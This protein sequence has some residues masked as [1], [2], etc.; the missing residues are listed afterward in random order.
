M[1]AT[2]S[3]QGKRIVVTRAVEQ[4][5][6]LKTR[7]ESMGATVLLFPAVKFSEPADTTG[8]DRA[9]RSLAGFD[10]VLFTSANAVRFFAARCRKLGVEPDQDAA[11]RCAA[12][13]PATASAVA[14]EGFSVDHVA[15]EFLGVA[16][17]RE[18][19]AS[20]A[21]KKILLPRSERAR[22]DLPNALRSVGAEVTEVVAYHTGGVGAIDP[23]VMRAMREAEVDVISFFSPS[24][25][26]NMRAELG[27]D[28]LS[29]LG[30][31]AA[32]AAVGPVT[33]SA[34]RNAGLP[35]AIEA[36][37]TTAESM[38]A[39]IE[40]YFSPSADSKVRAV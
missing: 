13:G 2:G 31:R 18:L 17:A 4:A 12:V 5:R 40:K 39:A 9:I 34:L 35:V 20:L 38:A 24:A 30:T 28:V 27:E 29:R 8:L 37:L 14:A 33:A 19:S 21:G 6:G 15:Q 10:W 23:G 22:A 16:L 11:Y 3:L 7:L 25:I 36:P 1:S 32:L 26:E